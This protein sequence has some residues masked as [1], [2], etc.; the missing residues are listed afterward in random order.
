ME[1][2][3]VIHIQIPFAGWT[4][5]PSEA[6]QSS[7]SYVGFEMF[8]DEF[9]AYATGFEGAVTCFL[10]GISSVKGMTRKSHF[11]RPGQK[12]PASNSGLALDQVL[13]L[14]VLSLELNLLWG[15]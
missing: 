12:A 8:Q 7:L 1:R 9:I 6:F 2:R 14:L 4:G 11:P 10:R 15:G 3:G 5:V 13:G